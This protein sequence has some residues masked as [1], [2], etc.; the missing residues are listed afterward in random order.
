VGARQL[1]EKEAP[2]ISAY[3][4]T[5]DRLLAQPDVDRLLSRVKHSQQ[6]TIA[7][8]VRI[9]QI[10]APTGA[11]GERAA[12]VAQEMTALGLADVHTDAVGNAIGRRPG[13]GDG[14]TVMLAAHTDT[15][16]PA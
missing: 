4:P 3:T 2:P 6:E 15:V 7:L 11:E 1:S 16:F 12:F 5:I 13:S 9:A 14:P 8:T 10:P